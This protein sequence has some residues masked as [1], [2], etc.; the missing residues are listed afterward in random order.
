MFAGRYNY[1]GYYPVRDTAALTAMLWC[2]ETDPGFLS[3]LAQACAERAPMF[4]PERE[5][6]RS[7]LARLH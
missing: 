5:S 6:W 3:E 2:A 1:P 4:A 7:V